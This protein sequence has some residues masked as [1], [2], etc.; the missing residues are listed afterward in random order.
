MDFRTKP[1]SRNEIRAIGNWVRT[2]LFK[3]KNKYYFDVISALEL[4][5][6]L[7]NNVTV[8]IVPND[9]KDLEDVPATTI[10]DMK[11][12][13]CIKIKEK[14]YDGAYHKKMVDIVII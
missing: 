4:L 11:G 5:P 8:E 2:C 3:C 1:T 12:N 9:D 14:V 13:Y 7:I 6:H 10:P